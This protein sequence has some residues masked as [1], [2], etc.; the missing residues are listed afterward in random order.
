MGLLKHLALL[1]ALLLSAPLH[2][3]EHGSQDWSVRGFGTLGLARSASP[4]AQFVRDLSQPQGLSAGRWSGKIDNILGL[5]G[6]WQITPEYEAVAQV[7]SHYRWDNSYRPE[8]M[9]AFL[10]WEPNPT[11]RLRAGRI[12][13][14]FFM[15][16]DS[17]FV[18]YANLTVRP[19]N[20]YYGAL[21]FHYFN[22]ADIQATLPASQGPGL[23]RAKLFAG[24]TGEQAPLAGELWNLGQAPLVGGHLEYRRGPWLVRGG[25]AHIH[26]AHELPAPVADLR[27]TL[28]PLGFADQAEALS[29]KRQ[30]RFYSLGAVYDEGP[31]MAQLMLNQI[32]HDST[33]FQNSHAGYALVGYRIGTIT[34]YA[35]YAWVRSTRKSFTPTNA[36]VLDKLIATVLADSHSHQGTLSLGV[37]WDVAQNIALKLQLDRVRGNAD[38]LFPYRWETPAWNGRTTVV[39]AIMDFVF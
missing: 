31:L 36:P 4:E 17:R 33:L 26:F 8:L 29:V 11:L 22:G 18:G 23:W 10:K 2:A 20:D 30:S 16:A 12:G 21:P 32:D 28:A 9:W 38:S 13:T 35:G 3:Q 19:A 37:R 27:N 15:Q 7:V 34:P 39:S 6:N 24:H 14:D 25:Y 5:Q 1:A